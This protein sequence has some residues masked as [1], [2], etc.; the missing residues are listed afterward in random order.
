MEIKLTPE[1]LGFVT[2]REA[3]LQGAKREQLKKLDWL[4]L[5]NRRH[6]RKID[7]EKIVAKLC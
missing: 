5:H 2:E 6:Y 4:R 1:K 3:L 7:I